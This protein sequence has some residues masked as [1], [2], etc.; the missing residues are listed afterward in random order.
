MTASLRVSRREFLQ[1]TL[2][3]GG[4][5]LLGTRLS[6]S[7]RAAGAVAD[8]MLNAWIRIMPDGIVTIMAQNPEIGQGIKTML[9]MLIADEL[10]VE[11]KQVRVEQAGLDTTKYKN[12]YA[13][14]SEATPNHWLPMRQAGAAGRALLVSAA[15]ATWGVPEA[16]C[17]T[18]AGT[19]LHGPSGRKLGYGALLAKA[20][21]L[22]PPALDQVKLKDPKDF[23]IIGTRVSGVDNHAIVTGTPLYSI[24][25]GLPGMLYAVYEKCPVFGGTVVSANLDEIKALWGVRQAFVLQG[26]SDLNGL[27]S[28][29]AIV[30]DSWWA[31][32][33]ARE[34]LKVTW[35]EGATAEQSSAGFAARAAELAKQPPQR[36]LRK[37]G[38]VE[39]ALASA[40]KVVRAE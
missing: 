5:L 40:A 26:G 20:A 39:A 34:Q 15:A 16:E 30:A 14:G 25:F 7:A 9:P 36:S 19:V 32:R 8:G 24:D 23:K 35:N 22:T 11:W 2:V 38:D 17:T 10:D 28:G 1:A 29:V 21:T 18:S 3:A 37:D 13:G 4:G 33:K 31:A 12:Q 6:A 27:L